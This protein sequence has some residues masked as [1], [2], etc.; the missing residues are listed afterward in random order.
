MGPSAAG[1]KSDCEVTSRTGAQPDS[2]AAQ[3]ARLAACSVG[4]QLPV[5]AGPPGSSTITC[6]AHHPRSPGSSGS[7]MAVGSLSRALVARS[8]ATCS[9]VCTACSS[10][11]GS[12]AGGDPRPTACR[13][14]PAGREEMRTSRCRRHQW[15]GQSTSGGGSGAGQRA[16]LPA[17]RRSS[18]R[19]AGDRAPAGSPPR[20]PGTR[21]GGG[22]GG[23]A[24]PRSRRPAWTSRRRMCWRG[25]SL[26]RTA[27]SSRLSPGGRRRRHLDRRHGLCR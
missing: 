16:A 6:A 19:L 4:I 21:G 24:R 11:S 3:C 1:S 2:S 20:A 12:C 10:P 8:S 27:G 13:A 26:D 25:R 22:S 23:Q 5:D 14:G 17:P 15:Q 18:G 7:R 9:A